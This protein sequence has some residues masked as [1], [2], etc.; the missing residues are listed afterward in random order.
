MSSTAAIR[1][2][3]S[4]WVT[5]IASL[6]AGDKQCEWAVWFKS[7]FQNYARMPRS[8]DAVAW[9]LNHTALLQRTVAKLIS[10]GYTVTT[11]NQNWFGL[12][13]SV[14]TLSGKPDIIA[15]RDGDGLIVDTKTGTP[16]VADRVQVMLY[17]WAVPKCL[18]RFR[19]V[20]FDGRVVYGTGE[21][22]VPG[23]DVDAKFIGRA[24]NTIRA[25]ADAQ[26]ARKVP[27]FS[28]CRFCPITEAD[29]PERLDAD[30]GGGARGETDE[31]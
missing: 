11:E 10:E 31:F 26:R 24:R 29:C 20:R 16:R 25:V 27:S 1:T 7:H 2:T 19:G 13:G 22:W 9:Q 6:L 28:E 14:G 5:G 17:L 4:I 18:P 12:A 30:A 8:N 21:L 3:P 15:V 23:D